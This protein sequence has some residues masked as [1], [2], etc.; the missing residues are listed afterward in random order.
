MP[1][2]RVSIDKAQAEQIMGG[3]KPA[4]RGKKRRAEIEHDHE[5]EGKM[6][7][8]LTRHAKPKSEH[9]NFTTVRGGAI[10]GVV[11]ETMARVYGELWPGM[12]THDSEDAVDVEINEEAYILMLTMKVGNDNYKPRKGLALKEIEGMGDELPLCRECA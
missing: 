3:G 2:K 4:A 11:G 7:D 1:K 5:L 8:H 12:K 9:P 6:T 10:Q